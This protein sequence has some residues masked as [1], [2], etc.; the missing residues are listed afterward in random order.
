M[1]Q[2][3]KASDRAPVI[4]TRRLDEP[5]PRIEITPTVAEYRQLC[6]DLTELRAQGAP[7]NTA[8]ILAAVS[9]AATGAKVEGR[10]QKQSPKR[11]PRPKARR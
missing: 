7:S 5:R 4:V 8:A 2:A 3:A 9:H 6:R 1:T 11:S 10:S